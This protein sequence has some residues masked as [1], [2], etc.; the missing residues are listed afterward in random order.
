MTSLQIFLPSGGWYKL[1]PLIRDINQMIL[2]WRNT[3][4][5]LIFTRT[6][7]FI[8]EEGKTWIGRNGKGSCRTHIAELGNQ[9]ST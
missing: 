4:R 8:G 1:I 5:A 2:N 3:I 6:K 7:K 9:G